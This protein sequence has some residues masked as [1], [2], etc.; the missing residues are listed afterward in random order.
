MLKRGAQILSNRQDIDLVLAQ[1]VHD[2]DHLLPCLAQSQH[3]AGLGWGGSIH[4]FRPLEHAERTLVD[5]LWA[6][7]PVE[8]GNR[9]HIVIVDISSGVVASLYRSVDSLQ[10]MSHHL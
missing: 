8:P 6:H 3:E 4:L 1:I 9:L 5:C 2:L 7:T 10:L